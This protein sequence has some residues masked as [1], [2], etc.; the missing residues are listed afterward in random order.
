[1][2]LHLFYS[3]HFSN[4]LQNANQYLTPVEFPI[5]LLNPMYASSR[6]TTMTKVKLFL[7]N[8]LYQEL[9]LSNP[10]TIALSIPKTHGRVQ[11]QMAQ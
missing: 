10:T 2:L 8:T 7:L 3:S 4:F 1:M 9:P 11:Q 6:K 5:A